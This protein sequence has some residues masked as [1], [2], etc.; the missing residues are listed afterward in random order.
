MTTYPQYLRR[1]AALDA[2]LANLAAA[3]S[4]LTEAR[5]NWLAYRD[6]EAQSEVDTAA[7]GV[8]LAEREVTALGGASR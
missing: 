3:K 1:S 4:D 6:R 7:L 8:E 2:A 5:A